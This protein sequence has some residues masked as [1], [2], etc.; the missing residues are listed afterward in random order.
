MSDLNHLEECEKSLIE[1]RSIIFDGC[2]EE[3][4]D[5]WLADCVGNPEAIPK[6]LKELIKTIKSKNGN[7]NNVY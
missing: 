7:S 2:S 4:E 3:F 6:A 5:Y 1:V